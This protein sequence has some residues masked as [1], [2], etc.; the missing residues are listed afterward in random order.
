MTL[1]APGD[2]VVVLT[3]NY[4]QTAV[5]RGGSDVHEVPLDGGNDWSLDRQRL[6]EEIVSERAWSRCAYRTTPPAPC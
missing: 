3:P 1:V 6:E 5:G 2:R 4:L